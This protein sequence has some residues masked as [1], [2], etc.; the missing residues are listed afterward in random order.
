[1]QTNPMAGFQASKLVKK[2]TQATMGDGGQN[3]QPAYQSPPP[4]EDV[5]VGFDYGGQVKPPVNP[6][7]AQLPIQ[8][9]SLMSG[10]SGQQLPSPGGPI[11]RPSRQPMPERIQDPIAGLPNRPPE[12]SQTSRFELPN[13]MAQPVETR[14]K[15]HGEPGGSP[16][17]GQSTYDELS[18]MTSAAQQAGVAATS[19]R[20]YGHAAV[21]A[22]NKPLSMGRKIAGVAAGVGMGLATMN[23]AAGLNTGMAVANYSRN[24]EASSMGERS[25]IESNYGKSMVDVGGLYG[26]TGQRRAEIT[27]ANA[28][29]QASQNQA[30]KQAYDQANPE[31]DVVDSGTGQRFATP[32]RAASPQAAVDQQVP[33]GG[34]TPTHGTYVRSVGQD[35]SL[36]MVNDKDPNDVIQP[37]GPDGNPIMEN[38]PGAQAFATYWN[39]LPPNQ[40]NSEAVLKFQQ[41]GAAQSGA[42]QDAAHNADL[43]DDSMVAEV[44][45]KVEAQFTKES[46]GKNL[47]SEQ[48]FQLRDRLL[49]EISQSPKYG[50][51]VQKA[52][53]SNKLY[54]TP[55]KP[56]SGLG[57]IIG[58]ALQQ[59]NQPQ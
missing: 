15:I 30:N 51:Y 41:A 21:D 28:N 57:A 8:Q 19:A 40:Q 23:P 25:G 37:V 53:T 11:A 39:N 22:Q 45:R 34:P 6:A 27:N 56:A 35:G 44:T 52:R 24:K 9:A 5:T 31:I 47:T 18:G 12:V 3:G 59:P 7:G 48:Q 33:V 50:P 55:P 43:G 1:M 36:L 58:Q 29:Q 4:R 32:K 20:E 26:Q 17:G 46:M 10:L 13:P 49:N 42:N 54:N 16:D 14:P 2:P 38:S